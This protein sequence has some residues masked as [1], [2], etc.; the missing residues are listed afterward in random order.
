MVPKLPLRLATTRVTTTLVALFLSVVGWS[1]DAPSGVIAL[2]ADRAEE[3]PC[4]GAAVIVGADGLAVTLAEALPDTAAKAGEGFQFT[5]VLTGGLRRTATIVRRGTTTTAVALRITDLPTSII[6]LRLGDSAMAQVGDQ[7]WTAGNSFGALEQDGA[8]AMSRGI[9]SGHYSIAADSPSVR[10]RG[11][12]VLSTY[13]GDVFEIDAAANDGNQG[14]ALLDGNGNLIGLVSLG[15]ARERRLG[16]TV[17]IHLVV[18]DL[19]L[20]LAIDHT[21]VVVDSR[22]QALVRA[23]AAVAPGL[24]LVYLERSNG[25]GNPQSVPRPPRLAEEVPKSERERQQ[26]WWD[27]YYHQQQMFYTDQA[28]TALVIDAKNGLLLTAASHLHGDSERGEVMLP[29][30]NVP[31]QVMATNLPL[32]LVLLKAERA[33]PMKE[34]SLE[35]S[36][37]LSVGQAMAVVGR[38][39]GDHGYTVNTGVISTTTRRRAQNDSVFAQ[40][41]AMANYGNLGGAVVDALGA[42]IGMMV[43]LSPDGQNMP[44]AINSGVAMFVDSATINRALP[45]LKDGTNT[46]RAPIIGLGVQLNYK[47]GRHPKIDS[48]TSGTGAE[49]AGIKS[50]DILLKVDGFDAT[51][52][53]AVTRALIRRRIGDK[54]EVVVERRGETKTMQVEIKAFGDEK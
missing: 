7:V 24:A 22:T 19:A 18:K 51:S 36:P 21:P 33:L 46:E 39:V 50:G 6:P 54:V 29:S 41:D 23:A 17:P 8:A 12:R 1:L 28:V 35:S 26:R 13:R 40:T 15:T 37:Q 2:P 52:P 27:A 9:I 10:G 38:H 4:G 48:V 3:V 25:L 42:A 34:I 31:C 20:E 16:T 44:W 11:G 5:V 47:K 30:G 43:M 14:G 32:D 53:Q 49:E 45:R